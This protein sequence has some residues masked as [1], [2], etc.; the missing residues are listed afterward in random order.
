MPRACLHHRSGMADTKVQAVRVVRKKLGPEPLLIGLKKAVSRIRCGRKK[1][2][3]GSFEAP[4]TVAHAGMASNSP[5]STASVFC[6]K[7]CDLCKVLPALGWGTMC[8]FAIPSYGEIQ[9]PDT[10]ANCVSASLTQHDGCAVSYAF[11]CRKHRLEDA[12]GLRRPV[13]LPLCR[14]DLRFDTVSFSSPLPRVWRPLGQ[15]P[16]RFRTPFLP[17]L[18]VR[19]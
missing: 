10:R 5:R 18:T 13:Q 15:F 19:S 1:N 17:S 9:S 3:C 14:G 2:P 8:L 7:I 12:G 6:E 11:R 16:L 4:W